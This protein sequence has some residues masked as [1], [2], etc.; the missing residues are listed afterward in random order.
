MKNETDRTERNIFSVTD[1][2]LNYLQ[3]SNDTFKNQ[4]WKKIFL[5]SET[6]FPLLQRIAVDFLN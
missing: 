5:S 6:L 1:L 3:R 4:I 2:D